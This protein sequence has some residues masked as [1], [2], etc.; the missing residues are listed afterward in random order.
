LR[1]YHNPGSRLGYSAVP[2]VASRVNCNLRDRANIRCASNTAPHPDS[3]RYGNSH[4]HAN[5]HSDRYGYNRAKPN[6]DCD[7]DG[8]GDC[9]ALPNA[10]GYF[11]ASHVHIKWKLS[12][13]AGVH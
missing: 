6:S 2:I 4:S 11:H 13:C 5:S 7:S 10:F 9:S 3:Y 12:Q 8:Y 1:Q